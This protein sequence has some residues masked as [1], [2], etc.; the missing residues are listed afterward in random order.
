[1]MR[2]LNPECKPLFAKKLK[3]I[4]SLK[5][6]LYGGKKLLSE[7]GSWPSSFIYT[8]GGER[9]FISGLEFW[10]SSTHEKGKYSGHNM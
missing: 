6:S 10:F 9:E 2:S 3:S 7:S 5:E 8:W 1:M 4:C